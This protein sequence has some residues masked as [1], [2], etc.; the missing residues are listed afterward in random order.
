MLKDVRCLYLHQWEKAR[1]SIDF[2]TKAGSRF[3]YNMFV[4]PLFRQLYINFDVFFL[5]VHIQ[6]EHPYTFYRILV[7]KNK[8][9]INQFPNFHY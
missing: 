9:K 5:Y 2:K 4:T 3:D 8:Q 1:F 7:N 6:K